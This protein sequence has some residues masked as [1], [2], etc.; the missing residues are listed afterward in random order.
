MQKGIQ[1]YHYFKFN[2]NRSITTQRMCDI[3]K[4]ETCTK[5][6]LDKYYPK[7]SVLEYNYLQGNIGVKLIDA[8]ELVVKATYHLLCK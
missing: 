5:A 8:K 3:G 2:K 7:Y 1:N 6:K 4:G